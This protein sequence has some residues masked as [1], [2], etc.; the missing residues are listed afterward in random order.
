ML[1]DNT[2]YQDLLA[3]FETLERKKRRFENAILRTIWPVTAATADA[4]PHQGD[5]QQPADYIDHVERADWGPWRPFSA[6][7]R[8]D[9]LVEDAEYHHLYELLNAWQFEHYDDYDEDGN[10]Y[11]DTSQF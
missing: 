11:V 1:R 4:Y 5:D 10:D 9:W 3:D 7:V 6:D 2:S 8:T